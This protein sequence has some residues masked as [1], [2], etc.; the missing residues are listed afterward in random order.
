[1]LLNPGMFQEAIAAGFEERQLLW[2]PN[3]VDTDAY[4][5]CGAE[6]RM[7]M[8]TALGLPPEAGI[9]AFV[10]RLAPEKELASLIDAMALVVRK[11]PSAM[12]LLIGEGPL[13]EDLKARA[14]GRLLSA[15][16]RFLGKRPPEQVRCWLQVS[17]VFALPSREEGLSCALLE[18]MSTALPSVVSAIPANTQLI[19]DGAQGLLVPVG[20]A[21][22]L[23][24]ALSTL[25]SNPGLRAR[26]GTEARARAVRNYSTASV[27]DRYEAL[28][29][30]AL[31]G[32]GE[33]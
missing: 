5:P 31:K 2:M 15:A 21:P 28:L 3:P 10:G 24:N 32:A 9:V 14:D 29:H 1:M 12:L 22:A 18:A 27:I 7:R 8:R 25:L 4:V 33:D 19:E 11:R 6:E 13:G 30:E 23:A 16:C 17:D 20:D 26:M